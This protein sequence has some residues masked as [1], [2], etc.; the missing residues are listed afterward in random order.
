[1]LR[2][3][4]A[5]LDDVS[6]LSVTT[7]PNSHA[8]R[9]SLPARPD[10]VL[11]RSAALASAVRL[12]NLDNDVL[13]KIASFLSVSSL[14][15]SAVCCKWLNVALRPRL[16]EVVLALSLKDSF[17]ISCAKPRQA[18]EIDTSSFFMCCH[19]GVRIFSKGADES[20]WHSKSL[21]VSAGVNMGVATHGDL[22]LV[23]SYGER[24]VIVAARDGTV[25]RKL[26]RPAAASPNPGWTKRLLYF[27][28]QAVASDGNDCAY[29]AS[30]GTVAVFEVATGKHLRSWCSTASD[31][32]TF[33]IA[34]SGGRVFLT[35]QN[36]G[37]FVSTADGV[38]LFQL[39]KAWFDRVCSGVQ[40]DSRRMVGANICGISVHGEFLFVPVKDRTGMSR[41]RN[42]LLVLTRDG[43]VVARLED[44]NLDYVSVSADATRIIGIEIPA[45]D[46]TGV[47]PAPR[48]NVVE[49]VRP[50]A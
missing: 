44:I 19:G 48:V 16:A 25:V 1:M 43:E 27:T 33:G 28:P 45:E 29:V 5:D 18:L 36:E 38:P 31:S 39:D 42:H 30:A 49:I 50:L 12:S 6:L 13:L 41:I 3:M 17:T 23:A 7:G 40:A 11:T 35:S 8:R 2:M 37:L 46:P 22:L 47:A 14:K 24:C 21:I 20:S 26:K 32:H 9:V 4:I 10:M 15:Q 34:E